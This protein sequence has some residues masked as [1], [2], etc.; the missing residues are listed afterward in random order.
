M[1]M[2]DLTTSVL[3]NAADTISILRRVPQSSLDRIVTEE[4]S[5]KL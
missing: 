2:P 3:D 1:L 5:L 4:Y